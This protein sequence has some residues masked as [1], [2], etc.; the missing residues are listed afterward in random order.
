MALEKDRKHSAHTKG[1]HSKR[2]KDLKG[3]EAKI[4]EHTTVASCEAHRKELDK[5]VA[6]LAK[7]LAS[8]KYAGLRQEA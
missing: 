3:H 5:E 4:D 1:A 8:K 7:D 6:D 2:G